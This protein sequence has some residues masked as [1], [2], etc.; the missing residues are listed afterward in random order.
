MI[1]CKPINTNLKQVLLSSV[2]TED[3]GKGETS[4][5][6]EDSRSEFQRLEQ[7]I[8]KDPLIHKNTLMRISPS[9]GNSP[10]G[11]GTRLPEVFRIY[12]CWGGIDP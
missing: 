10:R 2:N 4:S 1:K 6:A 11:N 9:E 7:K 3:E 8:K 5:E 12:K